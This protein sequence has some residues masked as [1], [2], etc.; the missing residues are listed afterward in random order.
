MSLGL[1]KWSRKLQVNV[2]EGY[3]NDQWSISFA[4]TFMS[5]HLF[6]NCCI[7]TTKLLFLPNL[8]FSIEMLSLPLEPIICTFITFS[9]LKENN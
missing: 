3:I 8:M 6:A 9:I 7:Q 1:L 2:A 4:H 5:P